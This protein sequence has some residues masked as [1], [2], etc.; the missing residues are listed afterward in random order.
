LLPHS[1]EKIVVDVEV[2]A[3]GQVVK[4][5]LIKGLGTRLDQIVLETVRTW[6]F[7]PATVNGKAVPTEAELIFPFNQDYPIAVS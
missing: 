4:E 3:D 5:K 6:R 1:A 7:H 2:D